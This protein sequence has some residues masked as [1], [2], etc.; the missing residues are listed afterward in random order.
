MSADLTRAV[1]AAAQKAFEISR[2][3]VADILP[4]KTAANLP[5]WDQVRPV[6]KLQWRQKV[7][8]LVEAAV[9]A[10]P[11]RERGLW[12]EGYYANDAGIHEDAC[13]YPLV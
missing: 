6:E 12:L 5:H 13:P 3:E 1:E 9:G 7:L 11:N 10:L 4:P 2:A 8:P